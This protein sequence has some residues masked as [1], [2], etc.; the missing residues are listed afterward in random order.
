MKDLSK[1]ATFEMTPTEYKRFQREWLKGHV[2]MLRSDCGMTLKDA[3]FRAKYDFENYIGQAGDEARDEHI[4]HM[5]EIEMKTETTTTEIVVS[6]AVATEGAALSVIHGK[7]ESKARSVFR[8][9]IAEGGFDVRLG[10]LMLDLRSDM[11]EGERISTKLIK[12]AGIAS[13]PSQRRSEALRL[14]TQ[15]EAIDTFLKENGKKFTSLTALFA[16]IDKQAKLDEADSEADSEDNSEAEAGQ[17]LTLDMIV[18]NFVT[19]VTANGFTV[20]EAMDTVIAQLSGDRDAQGE[21]A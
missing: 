1:V 21:A 2:A 4:M 18:A 8:K 5:R 20:E 17:E 11:A 6:E 10:N 7:R 16:A 13:I 3:K 19:T 15:R 14:V 12:A 9:D